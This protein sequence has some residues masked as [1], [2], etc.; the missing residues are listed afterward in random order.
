M[1]LTYEEKWKA[2]DARRKFAL[3]CIGRYFLRNYDDEL[4]DGQMRDLVK[5]FDKIEDGIN[6]MET[7]HAMENL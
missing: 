5:D 4:H 1:K 7:K 2:L 6:K 3:E